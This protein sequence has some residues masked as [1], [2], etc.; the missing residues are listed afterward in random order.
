MVASTE[1]KVINLLDNG[2]ADAWTAVETGTAVTIDTSP[3][4]ER[5]H[6]K[7]QLGGD[8]FVGTMK[9]QGSDDNSTW[10]DLI[11]SMVKHRVDQVQVKK[12]MRANCTAYT[13]GTGY[14][15]L[16]D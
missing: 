15:R 8:D 11:A 14:V 13:S 6:L 5:G 3:F 10:T 4:F 7:A 9:L 12:Y 1:K 2:G 16:F